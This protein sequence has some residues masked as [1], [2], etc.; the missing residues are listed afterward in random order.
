MLP[1]VVKVFPH[2]YKRVL[3]VAQAAKP[4][5]APP[6]GRDRVGAAGQEVLHG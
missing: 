2:E 6:P 3:G 4:V 1:K 5:E